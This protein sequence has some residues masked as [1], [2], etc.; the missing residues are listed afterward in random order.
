MCFS[1]RDKNCLLM[2]VGL[3]RSL[4]PYHDNILYLDTNSGAQISWGT[5]ILNGA[6]E[7][8]ANTFP[9]YLPSTFPQDLLV[10]IKI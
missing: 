9:I 3:A 4:L 7:M 10:S 5:L 1:R 6:R 2:E 8:N